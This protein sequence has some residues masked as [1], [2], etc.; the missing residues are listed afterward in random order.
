[1]SSITTKAIVL[2]R[3]NYGEADRIMQVLTPD[4]GKIG[5]IAKSVR[6]EKSKLAGGIELLAV[7]DLVLHQG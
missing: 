7:C 6:R 1:M 4:S 3:V 2:S 5:V